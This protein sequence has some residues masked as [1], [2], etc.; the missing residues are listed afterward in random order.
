MDTGY[1]TR[2]N[3]LGEN[4]EAKAHT[5]VSHPLCGGDL[6]ISVK[7]VEWVFE[8]SRSSGNA[9]NVLLV[10]A[11]HY[12]EGSSWPSFERICKLANVSRPTLS[13]AISELEELGEL[14]VGR[15][16]GTVNLYSFPKF[17]AVNTGKVL[18]PNQLSS[19]PKPVNPSLPKELVLEKLKA[20]EEPA[21]P[22]VRQFEEEMQ[23]KRER[24]EQREARKR[25]E[26]VF[27][28]PTRSA[29]PARPV[30]TKPPEVWNWFAKLWNRYNGMF[31]VSR[32][33]LWSATEEL[34]EKYS[35]TGFEER[36]SRWVE[37]REGKITAWSAADFLN[38]CALMTEEGSGGDIP[39][40]VN[41]E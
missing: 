6:F 10:L 41:E 3:G 5:S 15:E 36:L 8:N 23:R 26:R 7:A 20:E 28:K 16:N 24:K 18:D 9:R 30:E 1:S 38:E 14:E 13:K 11:A 29:A 34:Y 4:G 31:P 33:M 21:S 17:E 37:Q 12:R 25:G 35:A 32:P 39:L 40:I 27:Q 19:S 22:S 2:R